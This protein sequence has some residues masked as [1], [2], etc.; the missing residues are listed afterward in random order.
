MGEVIIECC[1]RKIGDITRTGRGQG[2]T[3]R[4]PT[5]GCSYGW[6]DLGEYRIK[7]WTEKAC[8]Q[9]GPDAGKVTLCEFCQGL[10]EKNS[11]MCPA[12]R[13]TGLLRI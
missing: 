12:C 7:T 2:G 1:G 13:G 4:C 8:P 9:H 6:K 10:G 5:C 3:V 11:E